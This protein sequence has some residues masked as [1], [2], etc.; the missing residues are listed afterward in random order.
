MP[1]DSES[2]RPGRARHFFLNFILYFGVLAALIFDFKLTEPLLFKTS[3]YEGWDESMAYTEASR[4]SLTNRFRNATYGSI[5]EFK[6]RIAKFIYKNFDP[7]GKKLSPRRWT[8]NVLSSYQRSSAIF[9]S[10]SFDGTYSRGILDRRPFLIARYVNAIGG[11]VLAAIL[12]VFWITRYRYKALFLIIPLLWFLLSFG[13]QQEVIEVSPNGWNALLAIMIFVALTDVIERRRPAGLYISAVLVGFGANSKIDFLLLG[14]PVVVTWIVAGFETRTFFRRWLRPA[15][16][17]GSLFLAGLILTNPR[18]L[19]ALPLAIGEQLHLLG[20]VRG[21]AVESGVSSLNHNY[22]MLL[23]E[24]LAQCVGAP[25]K[26]AKLH[27][28]SAGVALVACL[29]FPLSVAIFSELDAGR[30]RSLLVVLA[31]FYV[32]LWVVSLF[33]SSDAHD[34]YFL[35][36]SAVAMISVGYASLYLWRRTS[37]VS[38]AFALLVM[39]LCLVFYA[40]RA[41]ETG[42]QAIKVK[43]RLI[44]GDLDGT[45]SR[46]QAVSSM[47]KL[48]ETGKYSKRVIIDQHSYTDIRAFLEKGISPILINMF[49]FR[50]ELA[51]SESDNRSTLGLYAPGKGTGSAAW[52]GKWS[53]QEC[54]LYDSYVRYL[55]GF[56][57]VEKFGSNPMFL[58]DWGPVDPADKIVVFETQRSNVK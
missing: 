18:L 41:K 26:V 43:E 57:T 50:Q 25:W 36:G 10:P 14:L 19:Y 12:C 20:Q 53:D 49:N 46:N 3:P 32:S 38:R 34:R 4:L 22:V 35:S 24:F 39:C 1:A 15:L 52:E 8:N 30:K 16:T 31:S 28:L 5:E 13:Y 37:L 45:M 51:K 40:G 58:L 42:G 48:I 2:L 47:I 54:T 11:L 9:D 56:D 7:V 44:D 27:S 21:E 6:F 55:S 17:C 23:K 29:F 33:F